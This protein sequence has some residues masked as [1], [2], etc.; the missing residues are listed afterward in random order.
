MSPAWLHC[1]A[2]FPF[3][4]PATAPQ[5][6]ARRSR[7]MAETNRPLANRILIGL[8]V[9]AIAG[10]LTLAIGRVAPDVLTGAKWLATNVLDPFGQV[11]LRTL[12]FVVIPLVLPRSRRA[13]CNS[14]ASIASARSR[15]ARSSCSS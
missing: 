8:A 9:G 13:S 3:D 14:A 6:R 7:F 12:F 4:N 11:F 15:G 5:R 2:Q 10:V 1:A